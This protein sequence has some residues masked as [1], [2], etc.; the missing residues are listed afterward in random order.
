[1]VRACEAGDQ[2][3]SIVG[4]P[5]GAASRGPAGDLH[6]LGRAVAQSWTVYWG[7]Q[8]L[9]KEPCKACECRHQLRGRESW[10]LRSRSIHA[11]GPGTEPPAGPRREPWREGVGKR[12]GCEKH[13]RNKG[14]SCAY[15][16]LAQR[17]P[18]SG[19]R[20]DPR[21]VTLGGSQCSWTSP[22]DHH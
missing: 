8:R 4:S 7:S 17:W 12:Q 13:R 18:R 1:M 2:R 10:A 15:E 3:L 6:S 5:L 9:G 22:L 11:Q 20:T 21:V 19:R 14:K 16:K